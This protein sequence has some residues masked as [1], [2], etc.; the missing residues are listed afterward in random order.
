MTDTRYWIWLSAALG[1]G[2][3]GLLP[4]LERFESAEGVFEADEEALASV[5]ALHK[6][7]REKLSVHD[8]SRADEV[9]EYCL[10]SGVRILTIQDPDYP[11]ALL[12][13]KNPPAVLYMR[14][15]IPDWNRLPC[16]ALVG[17]RAMSYYGASSAA[18]IAYDLGRMGCVT[19]SGMALGIDG[20]SAA[21]TLES[22][23]KTIA[24]LG[25][26]I[27]RIYPKEHRTLYRAILDGGGT[28]VTEFPPYEG[29]DG[30]HF[31]L[32]NRIISGIARAVILVEG[33]ASS[34]AL[35]TAQYAKKQGKSVFAVPGK[36]NDKNSEAPLLLLKRDAKVLTCADDIYDA[37][38]EEYFSSL[39]PFALLP[40]SDCNVDAVMRK[41][42]IAVGKEKQR[43]EK[44]LKNASGGKKPIMQKI[45][46]LLSA[47]KEKGEK[48]AMKTEISS[49][50][51][52]EKRAAIDKERKKMLEPRTY[53]VYEKLSYE[54]AKHPDELATDTMSADA[55]SSELIMMEVLGYVTLVSGGS[56]LKNENQ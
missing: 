31:P 56:Y 9:A 22:G 29:A 41:Y 33:E 1:Y 49:S 25:S 14:G 24:V 43:S 44:I 4:L 42:G 16:I 12:K 20:V 55:V 6:S 54:D 50:D 23:G 40:K 39:N 51:M 47:D 38:R 34:G 18:E 52:A 45:R 7:E 11:Q 32:R 26:G 36:I 37:F 48:E 8:L 27:D 10:H 46:D 13:I 3:F 21:A 15:A 17:A 30:F 2:S 19:V 53:A 28:I 5:S 35:I